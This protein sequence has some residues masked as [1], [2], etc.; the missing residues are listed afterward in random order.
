LPG[1]ARTAWVR[2]RSLQ[3]DER[4]LLLAA[5]V[6]LV[7]VDLALRALPLARVQRLLSRL[8]GD[9]GRAAAVSTERLAAIVHLAARALPT[10]PNC[11]RRSVA[12]WWL[13]LRRGTRSEIRIGVRRVPDAAT[14]DFHAWVEIDGCVV[15]DRPDLRDSYAVFE[16][17]AQPP[18]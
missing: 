14:P 16:R 8:A 11:L 7:G 18:A 2:W 12:L 3:R 1:A 15:N 13:L 6:L 4:G 5:G 17:R 10:H 9:G